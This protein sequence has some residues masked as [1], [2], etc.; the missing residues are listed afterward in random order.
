MLYSATSNF[1]LKGSC[2]G[3]FIEC[4]QYYS[5]VNEK[6]EGYLGRL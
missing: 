6:K 3:D 4:M 1:G 5:Y 2:K